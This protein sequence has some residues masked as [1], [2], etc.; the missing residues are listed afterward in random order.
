MKSDTVFFGIL[1]KSV[2]EGLNEY[3]EKIESLLASAK[4][5]NKSRIAQEIG[6][7]VKQL[8]L[9]KD[10]EYSEWDLKMQEHD[11][12]YDMLFTNFFR[13]SFIV[14][15]SLALED[16]LHRFCYA[17]QDAKKHPKTPP[18]PRSNIIETYKNYVQQVGVSVQPD[19]WERIK[20]LN[21][22]RNCIVHSSG[23]VNRSRYKSDLIRISKK[24]IGINI[25]RK[26]EHTELT[27]LYLN[28]NMLMFEPRY[29]KSVIDDIRV[30]LE[31]LCKAAQLPT[32]MRF[33]DKKFIF[34]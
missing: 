29:C 3:Y 21:I 11:T 17:L 20:D 31:A 7:M 13:Y 16:H 2:F 12:T 33:E 14:L 25:S 26:V 22:I 19:L 23:N 27:P 5:E 30:L 4:E 15:T 32:R 28:D 1:T 8:A 6:K 10:E 24:D 34:E 18:N 9:S